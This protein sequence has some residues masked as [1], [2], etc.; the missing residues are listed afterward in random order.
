MPPLAPITLYLPDP[1]W[2]VGGTEDATD[3][4]GTTPREPQL[5]HVESGMVSVRPNWNEHESSLDLQKHSKGFIV[6][7]IRIV[8]PSISSLD[9]YATVL[10]FASAYLLLEELRRST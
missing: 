1:V 9:L 8:Q 5:E 7:Q 2:Q 4:F 6:I 10:F 3:L